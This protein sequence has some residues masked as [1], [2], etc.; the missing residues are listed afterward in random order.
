MEKTRETHTPE[1]EPTRV[2]EEMELETRE[3][4]EAVLAQ[5]PVAESEPEV[6]YI[7][8]LSNNS[9]PAPNVS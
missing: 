1:A 5:R 8:V 2:F 3:Q 7:I 6:R 4:R 9:K